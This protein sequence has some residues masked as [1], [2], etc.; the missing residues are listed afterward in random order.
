LGDKVARLCCVSDMGLRPIKQAVLNHCECPYL[1]LP[2][3]LTKLIEQV[4]TSV[5]I[6]LSLPCVIIGRVAL[7]VHTVS[8][9]VIL[10]PKTHLYTLHDACILHRESKKGDTILLSISLL[11]I[12]RFSQ[13]FHRRTQ[14]ELCN[15]ILIKI[16]PHLTSLHY[17]VKCSNTV[18]WRIGHARQSSCCNGRRL[19]SSHLICGLRI[20]QISTQ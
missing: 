18:H 7:P 12:D 20:A 3:L 1:F 11:N 14:L 4:L 13:F 16:P 8:N 9:H 19:H 6:F 2:L 15:K 5:Q 10:K 17:L